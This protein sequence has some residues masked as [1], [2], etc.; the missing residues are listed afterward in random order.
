MLY[1][2][3]PWYLLALGVGC[4]FSGV[5]GL[6]DLPMRLVDNLDM[7]TALPRFVQVALAGG[8]RYLAAN[9]GVVR[10]LTVSESSLKTRSA[11]QVQGVIQD[12]ASWLNPGH[13]DNYYV[14]AAI[15]PWNGQFAAGDRV[16][17]RA[18]VGRPYDFLPPFFRGFNHYYFRRDPLRGAA[19]LKVAA[20]RADEDNRQAFETIAARWSERG[21]G[22]EDALRILKGMRATT[23]SDGVKRYLDQRIA[24]LD[25]LMVLREAATNLRKRTGKPL[26]R[27]TDLIRPG[28]V[29]RL[30]ANPQGQQFTLDADGMP[31]LKDLPAQG[32]KQP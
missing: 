25:Q 14:A 10:A 12:D 5:A 20:Q 31:I 16:L 22:P 8:D 23:R 15:L 4:F 21:S 2:H 11:Y 30:P 3:G 28:G 6:T 17:G 24:N 7:Q 1:R 18:M 32:R 13:E 19:Y 29:T 26:E 27:L 9:I